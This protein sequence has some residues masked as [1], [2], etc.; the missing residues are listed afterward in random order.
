[1]SKKLS[2]STRTKSSSESVAT[3]REVRYSLSF[4]TYHDQLYKLSWLKK[5]ERGTL[6]LC[7]DYAPVSLR[8]MMGIVKKRDGDGPNYIR[9]VKMVLNFGLLDGP[10]AARACL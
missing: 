2:P 3:C 7:N 5:A 9:G 1:M 10:Q 6:L 8:V 4:S